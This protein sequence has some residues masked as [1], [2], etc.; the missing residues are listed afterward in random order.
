[1]AELDTIDRQMIALLR[2]NARE[3]IATLAHKLDISRTTAR[4][5][6][7]RLLDGGVI[8]GF[9]IKGDATRPG[10]VRA[11]M[12]VKIEGTKSDLV[13]RELNRIPEVVDLYSTSGQWDSIVILETDSLP[14]FDMLLR[15]IAGL[16]G[17][18]V[19]ETS[20]MLTSRRSIRA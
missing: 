7:K 11:V 9:T 18:K 6:L 16:N 15:R 14:N 3:P 4:A 1:M 10:L 2:H 19:T 8:Q 20:L 12:L 13:V 5:R 17:V